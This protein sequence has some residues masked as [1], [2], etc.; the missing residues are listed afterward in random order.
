MDELGFPIAELTDDTF[1]ITKAPD[2]GGIICEQSCKEQFLYEVHD[3]AN[4][5]TPDVN[6]DISHATITQVGDNRVRIGGVKGKPRPRHAQALRG[7]P[8]GL[9]DCFHAE[10]CMA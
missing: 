3:P 2:C 8:Q 1:E 10:L 5:L 6:V 9:E 4:Y 7:L